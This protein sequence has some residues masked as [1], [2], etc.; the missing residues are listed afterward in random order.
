M[1]DQLYLTKIKSLYTED[2]NALACMAYDQF[3]NFKMLGE[4]ST[5]D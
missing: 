4:M 5:V 3:Q 2:V 1:M